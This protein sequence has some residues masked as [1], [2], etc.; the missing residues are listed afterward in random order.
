MINESLPFKGLNIRILIIPI[1]GR[2]LINQKSGLRSN[3]C[4]IPY[5]HPSPCRIV[6]E[7]V[8]LAGTPWK[9]HIGVYM[10]MMENEIEAGYIG[11]YWG[12]I[13]GILQRRF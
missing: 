1:K 6:S 3:P 5:I 13:A 10:G 2:G 9:C 12:Y 8:E 11:S 4:I 7:K